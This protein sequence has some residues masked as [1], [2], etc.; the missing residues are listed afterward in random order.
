MEN[1]ASFLNSGERPA[2]KE[3]LK[4]QSLARMAYRINTILLLDEGYSPTQAKLLGARV[5]A[6]NE[7]LWP[8]LRWKGGPYVSGVA[9]WSYWFG[10]SEPKP[11]SIY[12]PNGEMLNFDP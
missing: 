11:I 12:P 5:K 8:A 4:K 1:N 9:E 10:G 2:L 7:M 6:P 3:S